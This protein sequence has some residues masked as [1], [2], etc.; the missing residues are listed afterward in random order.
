MRGEIPGGFGFCSRCRLTAV[1]H[2]LSLPHVSSRVYLTTSL[3]DRLPS[4][5][6]GLRLSLLEEDRYKMAFISLVVSLVRTHCNLVDIL[7]DFV[8]FTH[9]AMQRDVTEGFANKLLFVRLHEE[10]WFS[11]HQIILCLIYLFIFSVSNFQFPAQKRLMV[12]P[13]SKPAFVAF[14]MLYIFHID[15]KIRYLQVESKALKTVWYSQ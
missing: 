9:N 11:L 12:I 5:S 3:L 2:V 1:R 15:Q 13:N 4:A 7:M 8:T 6:Q 14:L 10:R